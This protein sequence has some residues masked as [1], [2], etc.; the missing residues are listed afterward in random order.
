[1][2]T[3]HPLAAYRSK[4]KLTRTALAE[5]VG[6]SVA[7]ISRIESGHRRPSLDLLRRIVAATNGE[8]K[9]D[10]FLEQPAEEGRAA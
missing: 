4:Q 9:A 7:T 10:D 2:T 1:M 5:A 3:T 6:A 8:L